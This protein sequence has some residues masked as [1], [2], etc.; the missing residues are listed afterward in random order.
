VV[1]LL[2][3]GASGVG[4]ST[5][6]TL[7]EPELAPEILAAELAQLLSCKASAWG[8]HP[9]DRLPRNAEFACDIGL[10]VTQLDQIV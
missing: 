7:V 6:R 9:P 4:T 2:V 10:G 1:L 3:T 5:A 8:E